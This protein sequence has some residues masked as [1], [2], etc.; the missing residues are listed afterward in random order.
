MSWDPSIY[1]QREERI[2]CRIHILKLLKISYKVEYGEDLDL[3][4][5]KNTNYGKKWKIRY[6]KMTRKEYEMNKS[7][8]F[9]VMFESNIDK[10]THVEI[11]CYNIQTLMKENY[12]RLNME[13]GFVP[14]PM[15]GKRWNFLVQEEKFLSKFCRYR[16]ILTYPLLTEETQAIFKKIQHSP[17]ICTFDKGCEPLLMR[18]LDKYKIHFMHFY[19]TS[20]SS[21]YG[22]PDKMPTLPSS[23]ATPSSTMTNTST[24]PFSKTPNKNN[25]N[26]DYVHHIMELAYNN[27]KTLGIENELVVVMLPTGEQ[28]LSIEQYMYQHIETLVSEKLQNAEF[29]IEK[30]LLVGFVVDQ[31]LIKLIH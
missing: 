15:S 9:F 17:M 13:S 5:Y 14:I 27:F 4:E 18:N 10:V 31:V 22:P 16:G 1:V 26:V 2:K 19:D 29:K 24:T 20:E 28:R 25:I 30:E 21:R 23:I 11:M 7:Y 3:L 6:Y 12:I 8:C